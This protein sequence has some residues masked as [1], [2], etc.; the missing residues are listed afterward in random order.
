ME[1]TSFWCTHF[2]SLAPW[3]TPA[4]ATPVGVGVGCVGG[5][6]ARVGGQATEDAMLIRPPRVRTKGW[7]FSDPAILSHR[8]AGF[9][10]PQKTKR[11]ISKKSFKSYYVLLTRV[12]ILIEP[13]RRMG[14][15]DGKEL[16][17]MSDQDGLNWSL[18]FLDFLSEPS[19]ML[20]L[21]VAAV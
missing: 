14:S 3:V 6:G 5:R 8:F 20:E 2:L 12:C 17:V 9:S 1:Q 16:H 11:S 19:C 10:Y 4:R 13:E 15:W 18:H 21:P 7:R